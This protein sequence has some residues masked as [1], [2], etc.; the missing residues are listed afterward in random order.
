MSLNGTQNFLALIYTDEELRRAFLAAPE[1]IGLENGLSQAEACELA[2]ILPEEI[3]FFS[4]TLFYKRLREAE[5]LLPLTSKVLGKD[6]ERHFRDLAAQFTPNSIKKHLEDA[7]EFA[8]F[9]QKRAEV[10]PRWAK[11]TARFEGAKLR[12]YNT[13]KNFLVCGFDHDI[14]RIFQE[15]SLSPRET[16]FQKIIL[17]KRKTYAFWL[18]IRGSIR[19]FI[20]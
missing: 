12:F 7:V 13:E 18:R 14:R 11:D 19:H 2:Q 20:W 15:S 17:P 16:D 1:K 3:N 4:E 8:A 10:N 6:F 9:L 5:K